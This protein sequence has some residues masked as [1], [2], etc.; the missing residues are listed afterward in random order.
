MGSRKQENNEGMSYGISL[1]GLKRNQ[2]RWKIWEGK[3]QEKKE[4]NRIEGMTESL[5]KKKDVLIA[6]NTLEKWYR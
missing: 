5:G 4:C 2:S 3:L 1:V 6:N